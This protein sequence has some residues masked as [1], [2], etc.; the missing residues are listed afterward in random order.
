MDEYEWNPP[1]QASRKGII[2]RTFHAS[3]L[4]FYADIQ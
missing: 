2:W 3:A 4:Q 1:A